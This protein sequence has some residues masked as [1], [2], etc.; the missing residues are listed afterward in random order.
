MLFESLSGLKVN[1][2]KSML[3]GVNVNDSWFHEA[4]VVMH[5]K[6]GRLP[7]LYLG[8][9]IGGDPRKLRFW[10]LLVGMIRRRLSGWSIKIDLWVVG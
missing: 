4:A 3:F 8:L 1:F 7:F 9:A 6:H 2:H 5:C 10:Y